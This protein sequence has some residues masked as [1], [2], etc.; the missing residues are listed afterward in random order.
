MFLSKSSKHN[1]QNL[2]YKTT[3]DNFLHENFVQF[4][5][6]W[7][8]D[9][10]KGTSQGNNDKIDLKHKT[11]KENLSK[12]YNDH[13]ADEKTSNE[14]SDDELINFNLV[15]TA[16]DASNQSSINKNNSNASDITNAYKVKTVEVVLANSVPISAPGNY[17]EVISI[18]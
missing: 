2:A 6:C 16:T 8:N 5:I 1:K 12:V 9:S 18:L 7:K 11:F 17:K 13:T 15:S 10:P 3:S 14:Y 4:N